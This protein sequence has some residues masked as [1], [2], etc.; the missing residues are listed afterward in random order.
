[1]ASEKSST[2][3]AKQRRGKKDSKEDESSASPLEAQLARAQATVARS[4][5]QTRLLH[6]QWRTYLLR[7]S[8]LLILVS[9][10]QMQGPSGACVK[11]IKALN[12]ASAEEE[13]ISGAYAFVLVVSD[14]FPYVLAI[15]IAALLSCFYQYQLSNLKKIINTLLVKPKPI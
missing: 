13:Q 7:F 10:H 14:S 5:E 8:Y 3:G 1:M 6:Q 11:D 2:A 4:E 9:M 12:A 15:I